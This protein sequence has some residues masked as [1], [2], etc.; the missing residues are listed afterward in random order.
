MSY[1]TSIGIANPKNKFEQATIAEFMVR[2]MQLDE[3]E[4][5]KLKALYRATGIESRYSVLE[6]YG[7]QNRFEFYSN[8][9]DME[10]FP[11]TKD[12]LAVFRKH[13]IGLSIESVKACLFK[14]SDFSVEDITH[15]IVVSCTGMYAPGLDID[16]IKELKL[17][18]TIERTCINFMGCYAAFNA[19]KLAQTFCE[20]KEDAKVL[21]VCTEL[22]SI[23]F[24]KTNNEDNW[25]ANSL[26]ADGAAALLIEA[27]PRKGLNLKQEAFYCDL[28]MNG[29]Q[30]MAWSVGD[31]GFEMRLSSYIPEVI[32]GGIKKL[33]NS[34]L[35]KLSKKLEDVS[36][37]AIHPG[38]KR[39]LEVIEEELGLG[40]EKNK[41]AYQVL[42]NFGNMS[43]PTVL[44]VLHEMCSSFN[45]VDNGKEILSFAFGPGLTM[46]SMLLKIENH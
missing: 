20:S 45:G 29:E 18:P 8:D 10:P 37:F 41:F 36:Y 44:F 27:T 32:R 43:S 6:D 12:R 38:G 25:L 17:K 15:L 31:L 24:Q 21:V 23:H 11:S 7:R 46:E 39:I 3:S 2:A 4:A 30:D 34:L 14:H 40:K 28:A 16:L 26:F 35:G 42:R 13:A 33:T 22:C 9:K 1:I 19:M 5:R